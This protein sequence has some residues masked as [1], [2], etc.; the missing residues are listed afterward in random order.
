MPLKKKQGITFLH[1]IFANLPPSAINW[2]KIRAFCQILFWKKLLYSKNKDI[3]LINKYY[4]HC[5]LTN[6]V[7]L[8][9]KYFCY[10]NIANLFPYLHGIFVC[11]CVRG[12]KK[13]HSTFFF[14]DYCLVTLF[15]LR[16]MSLLKLNLAL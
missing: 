3:Y 13:A 5:I 7:T 2:D 4:H 9:K 15:G 1:Y 6:I 14:K 11:I 12:Y 16:T 8:K 10:P